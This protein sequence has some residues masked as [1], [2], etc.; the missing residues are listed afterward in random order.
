MFRLEKRYAEEMI[1]HARAEAPNECCGIL[2]GEGS[3]IT[4]LFRAKNAELSPMRYNIDPRELLNIYQEIERRG[5][6][7]LGIYHSHIHSQAYPSSTDVQLALWPDSL[8]FIV[9]LMDKE[10]PQIRAFRIVD[11]VI[12]EED[13]EVEE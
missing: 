4:K 10:R 5:W 13:L 12:S 8:Y 3:T 6:E 2:A 1:T 11:G 9:S 7:F